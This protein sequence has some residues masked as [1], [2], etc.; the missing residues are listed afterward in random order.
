MVQLTQGFINGLG[1]LSLE[2]ILKVQKVKFYFH[3]L[4]GASSGLFWLYFNDCYFKDVCLQYIFQSKHAAITDMYEQL[5][6][7]C[8]WLVLFLL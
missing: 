4:R 8:Q 1:K 6:T 3:L 2:Y 7:A 5:S